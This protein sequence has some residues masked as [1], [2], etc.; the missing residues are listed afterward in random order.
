ML[1]IPILAEMRYLPGQTPQ[2][3][4]SLDGNWQ[5]QLSRIDDVIVA[6]SP[7]P[8]QNFQDLDNLVAIT[9]LASP[10]LW[11]VEARFQDPRVLPIPLEDPR[12]QAPN[13]TVNEPLDYSHLELSHFPRSS[14][15]LDNIAGHHLL[16]YNVTT[17]A[18]GLYHC[19]FENDPTANCTH[20]P[21]KLKCNY[22]YGPFCLFSL[23][24]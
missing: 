4:G 13:T 1:P 21:E 11:N 2:G 6:Y 16:Y 18:D 24:F 9:G 10:T 22:E 8:S 3:G 17:G 7:A 23:L 12:P 20:K 15:E 14:P 5:D 19:P